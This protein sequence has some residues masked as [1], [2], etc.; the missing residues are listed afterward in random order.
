MRRLLTACFASF[1][2][3]ANQSIFVTVLR[4]EEWATDAPVT[5]LLGE[6]DRG[7]V[8]HLQSGTSPVAQSGPQCGEPRGGPGGALWEAG[9]RMLGFSHSCRIQILCSTGDK[10]GPP[11]CIPQNRVRVSKSLPACTVANASVT[12]MTKCHTVMW[13]SAKEKKTYWHSDLFSM[14]K[15]INCNLLNKCR[16]FIL[17]C[18]SLAVSHWTVWRNNKR[19]K[20]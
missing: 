17:L 4:A 2:E 19:S 12:S 20:W 7:S 1:G 18:P 5:G 14:L 11:V 13:S 10:D 6:M 3:L 9:W 8:T 15:D 16:T